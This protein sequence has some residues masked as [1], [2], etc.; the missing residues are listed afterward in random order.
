MHALQFG[1]HFKQMD[2]NP[3]VY[4]Q[5]TVGMWISKSLK[6]RGTTVFVLDNEGCDGHERTDKQMQDLERRYALM[7]LR[8]SDILILNMNCGNAGRVEGANLTLWKTMIEVTS[9][10][11]CLSF[12]WFSPS[13]QSCS[14]YTHKQ[15]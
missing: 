8:A 9:V 13:V 2:P 6:P 4:G 1:T 5:N 10:D 12:Q 15:L 14:S 11:M 7:A 3:D